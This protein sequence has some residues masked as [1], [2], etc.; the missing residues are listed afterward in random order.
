[1]LSKSIVDMSDS[2][3]FL[4]FYKIGTSVWNKTSEMH[5]Y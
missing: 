4:S 5:E 1:M 3:V 2:N